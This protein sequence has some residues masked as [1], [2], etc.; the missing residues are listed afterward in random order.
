MKTSSSSRQLFKLALFACFTLSLSATAQV[1][2]WQGTLSLPAYDEGLPDPNPP[3][4]QLTTNRF[5]YPYTL[6]TNLTDHRSD[7]N[8]R[9]IFL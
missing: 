6:R 1:R 8:W 4:D 2:V 5:N 9:A 3:F 7:H